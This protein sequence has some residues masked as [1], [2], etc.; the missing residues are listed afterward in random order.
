M[1]TIRWGILGTGGIAHAF[2]RDI[3]LLPCARLQAAG[4]RS[5]ERA[6][7]F[8][9]EF[10]IPN[11]HPS[12]ESLAEDPEVD[13]V[14][15]ATPHS[16]HHRQLLTCLGAGKAVLCEKAFTLN[17]RQA[18]EAI[19]LARE[20][21]LFLMEGMWSR[22][23]PVLRIVR[24]WVQGGRIGTVMRLE[25]SFCGKRNHDFSHRIYNPALGGGALLDLGVYPIA[26]A[27]LVWPEDPEA[28][29]GTAEFAASGVDA[30]D[31]ILLRYQQGA[32]ARL[33]CSLIKNTPRVARLDGECGHIVIPHEWVHPDRAEL[34]VKGRRVEVCRVPH[35]GQ[36][37]LYEAAEAMRCLCEGLTE[38]PVMPL[39]DTLAILR[40]MDALRARWGLRYPGE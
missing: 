26:L 7:A 15:I 3:A 14:Y 35:K 18:Q 16:E 31:Q 36:G 30:D 2:A 6:A 37:L 17:V 13:I 24:D 39:D 12:C 34:W 19:G 29:E 38:S 1:N 10:S 11:P 4:S 8:A 40:I 32:E 28:V 22:F 21:K 23:F 20:K 25:A 9:A 5:A 33:E 27:N